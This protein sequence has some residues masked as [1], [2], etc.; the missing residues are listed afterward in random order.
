LIDRVT[1]LQVAATFEA[2]GVLDYAASL[3]T[4]MPSETPPMLKVSAIAAI[5]TIGD[6]SQ[7]T[8]LQQ[9]RLSPD[10]RLKKAA[11]RAIERIQLRT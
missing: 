10:V 8:I 9:F 4:Q 1:A 7:L 2:S 5:G 3:L 6:E 11:R